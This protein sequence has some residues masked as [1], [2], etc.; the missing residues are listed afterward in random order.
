LGIF[1]GD[2]LN[3]ATTLRDLG[4]LVAL[5]GPE[6]YVCQ[7]GGFNPIEQNMIVKLALDSNLFICVVVST[8]IG[9]V[10]FHNFR[11]KSKNH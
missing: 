9:F 11:V 2:S 8:Q 3:K 10:L 4:G 1:G 5:I 6:H 7:C